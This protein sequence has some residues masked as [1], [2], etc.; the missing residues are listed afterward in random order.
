[1][2]CE[3]M[4]KQLITVFFCFTLLFSLLSMRIYALTEDD[5]LVQAAQ[6]Q[7]RYTLTVQESRGQIYDV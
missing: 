6:N 7:S 3:S 4:Q 2:W 5:R 1:M